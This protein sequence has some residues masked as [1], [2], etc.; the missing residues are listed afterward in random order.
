M[1][2]LAPAI[3]NQRVPAHFAEPSH[4][5]RMAARAD[6]TV[7][8]AHVVTIAA[9]GYADQT[10]NTGRPVLETPD[11]DRENSLIPVDQDNAT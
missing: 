4:V 11:E 1:A 10:A 5:V 3:M 6:R 2:D 8:G 9:D 7:T